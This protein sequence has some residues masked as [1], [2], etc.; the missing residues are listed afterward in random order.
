ME[1]GW[2][3]KETSISVADMPEGGIDYS[4]CVP[5]PNNWVRSTI[6]R[7]F[8]NGIR[9]VL[10]VNP[11]SVSEKDF[12][13]DMAKD[14]RYWS[15]PPY[16]CGVLAANLK[17]SGYDVDI[18][19]LNYEMLRMAE[20]TAHETFDYK[21]LTTILDGYLFHI[22]H[23]GIVCV[24]TMFTMQH[25]PM[26]EIVKECKRW[27]FPV[28]VGG[29]HPTNARDFILNDCPDIDVLGLYECDKALPV[30]FDAINGKRDWSEVG[31]MI[32]RTNDGPVEL[33]S[34]RLTPGTVDLIKPDYCGIDLSIYENIGQVGTYGFLRTRQRK[35]SSVL[36][37]RGCRAKCSFCSVRY[38]NG[39]GVRTRGV[40][41]VLEEIWGLY[42][43]YGI[44]HITWLDDDLLSG[45]K[46]ALD[47]F[48]GIA[49][50][51]LDLTWDASNGLIAAAIDEQI[52]DAM[53]ASGCVGFNLGIE[54]GSPEILRAVHKPGTVDSFRKCAALT[55]KYPQL[56]IK[57]FVICGFPGET[58]A[59]M[60]QTVALC[61]ELRYDW[62]ALQIL[63]P[64]PST[65]LYRS[66]AD[67]GFINDNIDTEGKS[68]TAGVFSS[69]NLRKRE[70]SGTDVFID[71]FAGDLSRVPDK[72]EMADVWLAMDFRMNYEPIPWMLPGPKLENKHKMLLDV[73]DRITHNNPLANY[74]LATIEETRGDLRAAHDRRNLAQKYLTQ[75]EYWQRIFEGLN[76]GRSNV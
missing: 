41:S 12:R 23:A 62:C 61:V 18:C 68:F 13:L 27:K 69:L 63:N 43:Y 75:S 3:K 35:A 54:S 28:I 15:Y 31:Q 24:S 19:D 11:P 34:K 44:R 42:Y 10:L 74:Y 71:P 58:L 67:Q 40:D 25:E 49:K 4:L 33:T 66:M 9:R 76:I 32:I 21:L 36:S 30:F 65:E 59:Q 45:K 38:F 47:L 52:L 46:R 72:S 26:I 8:P 14:R 22:W 1:A 17:L 55:D 7:L 20:I 56:F 53:V 6:S 50:L 5:N 16:G 60:W 29:V 39:P 57:A 51:G 37:T 2:F 73:C 64:L 48:N 70:E